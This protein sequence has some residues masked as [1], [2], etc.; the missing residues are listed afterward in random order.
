MLVRAYELLEIELKT[1]FLLKNVKYTMIKMQEYLLN[2]IYK[3][4]VCKSV[5]LSL[6]PIKPVQA[7]HVLIRIGHTGLP[8]YRYVVSFSRLGA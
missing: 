1:T 6:N 4:H 8:D 2:T 7:S 3:P 5:R